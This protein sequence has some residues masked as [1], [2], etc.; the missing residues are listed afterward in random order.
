MFIF[1]LF[2]FISLSLNRETTNT[3]EHA[4]ENTR[5]VDSVIKQKGGGTERVKRMYNNK[6]RENTKMAL[7]NCTTRVGMIV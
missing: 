2:V 7:Y 4:W 5:T 3:I 1:Y 6:T